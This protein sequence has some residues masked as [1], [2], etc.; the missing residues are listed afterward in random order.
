MLT[1]WWWVQYVAA[2]ALLVWL[3]PEAR[4]ALEHWR[5]NDSV[6]RPNGGE[7]IDDE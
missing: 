2:V 7:A 4:E 3:V 1:G 6:R 5:D